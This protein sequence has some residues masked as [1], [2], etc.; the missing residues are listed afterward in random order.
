MTSMFEYMDHVLYIELMSPLELDVT[1]QK[2]VPL[3][4]HFS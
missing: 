1:Q 3:G 4:E 2:W